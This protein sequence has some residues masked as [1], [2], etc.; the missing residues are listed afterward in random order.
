MKIEEIVSM[1]TDYKPVVRL[2]KEGI[3]YIAYEQS[4]YAFYQYIK[5]FKVKN[6]YVKKLSK[7]IVSLGFPVASAKNLLAGR[8][9][10]EER[11]KML[12]VQLDVHELFEQENFERWKSKMT[13]SVLPSENVYKPDSS[14]LIKP[15]VVS[16]NDTNVMHDVLTRIRQFPIENKTPMDC[17]IFVSELKKRCCSINC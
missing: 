4:C 6:R 12:I 2:H 7:N 9:I 1:E 3:F 5:P 14:E 17:M 10:I 8:K 11:D 15:D 13:I 16:D